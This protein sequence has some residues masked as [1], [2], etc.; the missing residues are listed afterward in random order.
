VVGLELKLTAETREETGKGPV[1][2]L[3]A[4]GEIPAVLYGLGLRPH[5]LLV[6]KEDL[7]DVLHTE[8]GANVLIDLQVVE[9]KKKVSHLVMIKEIQ[10]HPFKEKFLHVDFVKVARDETVTTK[11]P[12][13][14]RGEA[15]TLGLKAGG[16]LQ[17]NIWEV[18]VECLPSDMPDHLYVDISMMEIGDHLRVSDLASPSGVTILTD[19]DDTILT[20]LAPRVIEVEV[21]EVA[22]IAEGLAPEEE[23]APAEEKPEEAAPP[24][25]GEKS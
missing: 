19:A 3:R 16:T 11:V 14:V 20:I 2:R 1:K 7:S 21:P 22:E 17:H 15:E 23:V 25:G 4:K 5:S 13:A 6:K 9:G 18:E 8:A 12:I 24:A 10:R